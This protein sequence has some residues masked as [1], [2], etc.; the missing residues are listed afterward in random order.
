MVGGT[1]FEPVAHACQA[2]NYCNIIKPC[3]YHLLVT[4]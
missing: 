3:R 2:C 1:G 4:C